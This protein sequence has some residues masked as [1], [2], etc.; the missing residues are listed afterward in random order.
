MDFAQLVREHQSMVYSC[1]WHFLRDRGLAEEVGQEVFL[2]LHRSLANLESP[3]HVK[4]WLRRTAV[5]RSIDQARKRRLQPRLTLEDVP[6]PSTGPHSVDPLLSAALQ[7]IV[8]S[9]PEKARAVVILRY[10]EDLDPS[11]IADLL[12]MP[13]GSV[14]SQ[15]QRALAL[16]RGKLSRSCGEMRI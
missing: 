14:K 10:Q 16:L 12:A 15:L 13:V 1:A 9:L 6:E 2:E 5:H 11:E 4:N 3:E 7:R 8:A